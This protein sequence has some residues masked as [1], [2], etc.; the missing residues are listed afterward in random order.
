MN[1]FKN[2]LIYR[3]TRDIKI[4][5]DLLE[6]NLSEF[7][8]FKCGQRDMVKF[9]WAAA[10]GKYAEMFTHV[11]GD[12]ILIRACK[13]E[14]ILPASVI[15]ATVQEKIDT[16]EK[17]L[18]RKLKKTEKDTLKDEVVM[19]LLPRAFSRNSNT[20]ALIMPKLGYIVVD[21]GSSKSA[22]DLL[23]LLRK[24]IGSL[25]VVPV[26]ASKPL[27]LILTE[28][29]RGNDLPT[30]FTINDE[31]E[32]KAVETE[33]AVLRCK[34]QDLSS[35]EI[36]AHINAHKVVTKLALNWQDRLDFILTDD[37]TIKRLKFSDEIKEQ[38]QDIDREDIVQRFDAD[39]H[40]MCGEFTTL[41]AQ[42]FAVI[43]L[44]QKA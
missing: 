7:K 43:E 39:L 29:V 24:S 5:A 15:K 6:V 10:L 25:P 36:Q 11:C 32:F 33:G 20:C 31:A 35:E 18:G 40:L 37:L 19:D 44:E 12:N 28:W 27:S 34:Q 17:D 1:W 26:V 16:Q 8:Y 22:E 30:G 3:F 21:A 41:F 38:N 14:K 4:S 42:L 13:E 9:G 2:A 23:S